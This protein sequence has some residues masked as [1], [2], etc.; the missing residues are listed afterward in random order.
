LIFAA[1]GSL[2]PVAAAYVGKLI[3]DGAVAAVKTGAERDRDWVLELVLIELALVTAMALVNFLGGIVRSNLGTK[4]GYL[5][6]IRIL[7]KALTL[8]LEHFEAPSTYDK[9]QNA[10]REATSRPLNLFNSFVSILGGIV[11]L[12]SYGAVLF[13][14]S[15]LVIVILLATTI[16]VFLV[17]ARFS[18]EAFR[19]FSWRAPEQR[20][21]RYLEGLLSSDNSVKEVKL[22]G[23]GEL[24]LSRY[25]ALYEKLFAEE[26][27]INLRRNFWSFLIG[28]VSTLG[29]YGCYAWI[30]LRTV[31]GALSLGDM[32]L[33]MSVFRG[34]Q[35]AIR[36]ILRA[37][38]STYED[39]LFLSNLFAFLE[40]PTRAGESGAPPPR[41]AEAGARSGFVLEDVTFFYPGTKKPA[42]EGLSLAIGSAEK[43]AIVGENGAGKSTLIKL[44]AGLYRP[45]SGRITLDGMPLAEIDP[46]Q[47]RRRFGV[48]LQDFVRYQLTAKDN[49]AL[50]DV[51]AI[52]DL[53]RVQKAA[54]SGG[55]HPIIEALPERYETQLGRLFDGGVDLS[56]GNWQKLAVSRAFM[57]DAD[58]LV[59]DE[60]TSALDAEAEHAL[61]ERFRRLTEGR[62][63]LLISHRFSTVRMADRIVVLSN[64]RV[65][66]IGTHAELLAKDGRYAHLF[67]LQAAGYLD[68]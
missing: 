67:R 40:L 62:M 24:M 50:G 38:S 44:L 66:E 54:E 42:L 57:R 18:G 9:L 15:P 30:A 43:L 59:L 23:F 31:E 33:Y 36:G 4:L 3:V 56:A 48:V 47:L 28:N 21:M 68:L 25:R 49:I 2:Y 20:R 60:P 41:K 37:I 8:D 10:R 64:G 16:P 32:T 19:V 52:D 27:S 26:R 13:A 17:E 53:L 51:A 34:G 5:I 55:A 65:Q 1:I 45:T 58:I 46:A 22:Y 35:G 7:E 14:F 11:Q 63:A 12:A 39:N 6:Q 61:F 29:L